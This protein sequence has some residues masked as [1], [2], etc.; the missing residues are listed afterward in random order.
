[1]SR[2]DPVCFPPARHNGVTVCSE[3]FD[4]TD[5]TDHITN[6]EK[7]GDCTYCG[8]AREHVAP[9]DEIAQ[10][11]A[12]RMGTFYGQAVDQLMY[13]SREGGYQGAHE[14][15]YDCLYGSIGLQLTSLDEERLRHDLAS[16]IGDDAW[17]DYDNAAL[18]IDQSLMSSW[19]EFQTATKGERR[20]FFHNIG[21][22]ETSHPDE[23][24]I[25]QFLNEVAGLIASSGLVQIVD[26][27]YVLSRARPF[28]EEPWTTAAELGPPPVEHALQSNRMNPPGIPMF[29]GAETDDLAA[30]ETRAD[31]MTI[32]RFETR[33]PIR[34]IDLASLPEVPGFFSEASREHI[35]GLAFLHQ[36]SAK[37]AE[38]VEQSNRINVDYI[39]TQILTEFL[40][41]YEFEGGPVDGIRYVTALESEGENTVLFATQ[42]NLVHGEEYAESDNRWL[43]LTSTSQYQSQ[44]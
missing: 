44:A 28:V 6:Y 27:G 1:M 2:I 10:F 4:D 3:C 34:L 20:F 25:I 32:G 35:Q 39:P 16:E 15:T 7:S 37:M 19:D 43:V 13:V 18:E 41:D 26:A 36:L 33:R 42:D 38:P 40:R 5:L 21:E 12:Q 8:T 14:D 23:R 9:F 30:M 22:P 29:Y 31:Q 11:V 17:C 24:S